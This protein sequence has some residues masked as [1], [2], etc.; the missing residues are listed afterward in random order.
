M[1]ANDLYV[2]NDKACNNRATPVYTRLHIKKIG[3]LYYAN[4]V[5]APNEPVT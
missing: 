1:L 4:R 3:I 5:L 2:I